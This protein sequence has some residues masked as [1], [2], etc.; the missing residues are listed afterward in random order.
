MYS[1]SLKKRLNKTKATRHPSGKRIK[2]AK[3]RITKRM[4]RDTSDERNIHTANKSQF[5]PRTQM[6]ASTKFMTRDKSDVPLNTNLNTSYNFTATPNDRRKRIYSAKPNLQASRKFTKISNRQ[7]DPY[8]MQMSPSEKKIADS[9]YIRFSSQT[10]PSTDFQKSFYHPYQTM[11]RVDNFICIEKPTLLRTTA[12]TGLRSTARSTESSLSNFTQVQNSRTLTQLDV[13]QKI[14]EKNSVA[15]ELASLKHLDT[16]K[17]LKMA[18]KQIK[19][20]NYKLNNLISSGETHVEVTRNDPREFEILDEVPLFVKVGC[21]NLA[22][23]AKVTFKHKKSR[24]KIKSYVAFKSSIAPVFKSD[25]STFQVFPDDNEKNFECDY[26]YYMFTSVSECKI[27]L[28]IDFPNEDDRRR[29]KKDEKEE[30]D[31][32]KYE[33]KL[34]KFII[35]RKSVP[36][37]NIVEDNIRKMSLWNRIA[38]KERREKSQKFNHRRQLALKRREQM[39][40]EKIKQNIYYMNRWDI[41][42]EKRKDLEEAQRQQER[43][44]LFKYWWIRQQKTELALK[45]IYDMFHNTRTAIIK[46]YREKILVRRIIRRLDKFLVKKGETVEDRNEHILRMSQTM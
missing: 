31:E 14:R 40:M 11:N 18:N 43:K 26:I 8:I 29:R 2:S 17:M 32:Q 21:K 45:T 46:G 12:N 16:R 37:N 15:T 6:S 24:G 9:T 19:K 33:T 4:V 10:A 36:Q 13:L 20:I 35:K 34:A 38:T 7:L 39:F 23:P 30:T 27:E 44:E 41:V 28:I 5:N 25:K 1:S 42:R 3:R 22:A